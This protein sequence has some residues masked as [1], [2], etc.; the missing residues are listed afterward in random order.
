MTKTQTSRT[1]TSSARFGGGNQRGPGRPGAGGG[2]RERSGAPAGR[3]VRPG[4]PGSASGGQRSGRGTA[5]S[6][7]GLF[8]WSA[9]GLVVLVVLV[10][11][12]VGQ[13]AGK[14]PA[15]STAG[16][17]RY[18]PAPVP[19][20]ILREVTHVPTSAYDAVGSVGAVSAP[21]VLATRPALAFTGKPGVFV[22]D[23]EFCPFCA[24]ER[25]AVITSLSR[26][27]TFTGLKTMQSSPAD[28]DPKTQTFEF[29]TTTYSSP[30]ISVKL[31]EMYG[32]DRPTGRH[33]VIEKPTKAEARLVKRYD[34]T[35]SIPFFDA[36][37]RVVLSGASFS[38]KFLAGLSRA[39]IA[40]G[41]SH[42]SNPVTQLVLGA[43]ND[44]TAGICAIDGGEPGTVCS[45]AGVLAAAATLGLQS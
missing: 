43:S 19:A 37:N 28:T 11:V 22:L 2:R 35:S 16:D 30:Y 23:G 21:S 4:R 13:T 15:S 40:A 12:L 29:A 36:G 5:R 44:L 3:D 45:S 1:Q 17:A 6:R 9:V 32:Q 38:P 26:F 33:P 7:T 25:W 20:S 24:A 42:P 41:L 8:A 31:L 14:S 18:T 27:G 10:V 34:A 39:T